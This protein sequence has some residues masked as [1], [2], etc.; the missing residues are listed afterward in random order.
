MAIMNRMRDNMP[1]ILIGLV[2]VFL[3][4]IIFEWGMDYLGMNRGPGDVVGIVEGKKIS[5]TEF[6]DLIRKQSEQYKKNS[7][8]D[9]DENTVRQ[10]REQIWNSLVTQTLLDK[11]TEKAGI[12]VTD[13][14]IIDWVRGENPPEFL[15]Q[16]FRDSTGTFR[17]DVY[18]QALNDPRNKE[19]WI[20]VETALRQQRLAEKMQSL[21]FASLRATEGEVMDR[22]I[23]QTTKLNVQY[24][25]FD[26]NKF[27]QD[28]AVTVT[29][30]DLRKVYDENTE[31][32]KRP[33][34]RKVS[35]V[36]FS[37]Q[38][39]ASDSQDVKAEIEGVLKQAQAGIDFLELQKNYT[40]A[41]TQPSFFKHGD[42]TKAKEDVIFSAKVGDL[43]GPVN[44]VDGYSIFKVLEEK[45]GG[46]VYVK[47]SHIL[48]NAATPEAEA[49]AKVLAKELIFRAK[50]GEDFNALAKEY[51]TEPAAATSGGELG[52][53]GK[54]RMVKPF[55]DAALKGRVGE[56]IGPVKTQFGLHIIKI[57]GR[58]N[59]EVKVAAITL[60][61]TASA[62]TKDNAFQRAQDFA[63]V[64]RKG[65]FEKEAES[66]GMKVQESPEFQKGGFI[67]GVGFNEAANKFAFNNDLGDISDAFQANNGYVV[68]KISEVKKD[69]LRPFDEVKESLKPRALRKKK[70]VQLK[71]IVENKYASLSQTNDL[72]TLSTDANV[73]VQ[74]TGEFSPSGNI[75]TVGREFAFTGKALELPVG[76][77]SS[78]VEGNRGYYLL[79]VLSRTPFDSVTFN[80]QKSML[81]AQV[82]QEKKQRVLSTW[83]DG[84][85]EKADITDN[86]DMFFR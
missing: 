59:R 84:L 86:R 57:E 8:K 85:K 47:A 18:E 41:S 11:E 66:F 65:V 82:L 55:E 13:Q 20:Q 67:P 50:K 35:Y 3:V 64:A 72:A 80:Q 49:K 6:S 58:D 16:Q 51:S 60:P 9:P 68:L 14:E 75:P 56:I 44:D 22:F 76:K 2:V 12:T 30:E 17:R 52:W 69:G 46:D 4:T 37:D 38:P 1:V 32:F 48:L 61:I 62:Q 34:V 36:F 24:A 40:E 53:F 42:M 28:N 39:S 29:D 25:F 78:P 54:G 21:V 83:M 27:I 10:I 23:D 79:K 43:V 31:E 33:A 74:T 7:G 77:I 19:I 26:P 71:S 45:R 15:A 81:S 5:Y 70:M 73:S 63:Y